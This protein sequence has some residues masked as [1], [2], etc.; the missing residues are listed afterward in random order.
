MGFVAPTFHNLTKIKKVLLITFRSLFITI[1]VIIIFKFQKKMVLWMLFVLIIPVTSD[2]T[3]K[4]G[5]NF[6][7]ESYYVV[8]MYYVVMFLI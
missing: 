5:E 3:D 6:L 1:F 8:I 7:T 2:G 4:K